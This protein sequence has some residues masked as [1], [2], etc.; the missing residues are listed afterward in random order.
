M[1][2]K[3]L[4]LISMMIGLIII[5]S[6][7]MLLITWLGMEI[8]SFFL[9]PFIMSNSNNLSTKLLLWKYFFI[10]FISTSLFLLSF[11]LTSLTMSNYYFMD[12]MSEIIMLIAMYIKLGIFP[13]QAWMFEICENLSWVNMILFTTIP[14]FGPLIIL[15]N[16]NYI[17]SNKIIL[18]SSMMV[19]LCM[20]CAYEFSLRRFLIYSSI[21]NVMWMTYACTMNIMTLYIYMFFYTI[22]MLCLMNTINKS[23]NK[24]FSLLSNNTIELNMTSRTINMINIM[25]LCGF[26]P[27]LGFMMKLE[28]TM[29]FMNHSNVAMCIPLMFCSIY[30]VSIY[31]NISFLSMFI[32]KSPTRNTIKT[33]RSTNFTTIISM[34]IQVM[35]MI[36]YLF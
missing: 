16:S 28:V 35:P 14:K 17:L 2:Q 5:A 3:T 22:I 21:M 27:L 34:I 6:S 31:M 18:M 12:T 9:F 32:K 15:W 13:F 7:H 33:K 36:I 25:S 29:V 19:W 10:Q 8:I 1:L 24:E 20:G 4:Y 11:T 23:N 30:M 26:P